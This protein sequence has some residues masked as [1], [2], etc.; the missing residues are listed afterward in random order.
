MT[1]PGPLT[2]GL[3][4]ISQAPAFM[5]YTRNLVTQP[6]TRIHSLDRPGSQKHAESQTGLSLVQSQ[7]RLFPSSLM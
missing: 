6:G 5:G 4:Y 2:L 1:Q 3:A 7:G